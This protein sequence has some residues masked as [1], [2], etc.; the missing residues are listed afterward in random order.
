MDT[1]PVLG[2]QQ[3]RAAFLDHVSAAESRQGKNGGENV[4]TSTDA[5]DLQDDDD[6]E[7]DDEDWDDDDEDDDEDDPEDEDVETWQVSSAAFL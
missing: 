3:V 5:F 6:A 1:R 2:L 4:V 7:D